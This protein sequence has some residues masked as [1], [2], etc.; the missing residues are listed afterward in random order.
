M[1][2]EPGAL[3]GQ[4]LFAQ[5]QT[6]VLPSFGPA[7]QATVLAEA[8]GLRLSDIDLAADRPR[9]ASC[10]VGFLMV[11]LTSRAALARARPQAGFPQRLVGPWTQQVYLYV[12]AAAQEAEPQ[13]TIHARMFAPGIGIVEDPATGAAAAALAGHLADRDAAPDATL[14][15]TLLQGE[16]FGRPSRI[17][18]EADKAGGRI[19]GVRV[20][21]HAVRVSEGQLQL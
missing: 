14:R 17:R 18:I 3:P 16:D 20:G 7:P 11:R 4:A 10:G 2:R 15:W 1:V 12:P 13:G 6:A 5:F 9:E 19:T 21:G 8:L